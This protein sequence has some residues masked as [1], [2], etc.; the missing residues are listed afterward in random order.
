MKYKIL[1]TCLEVN[2][3][4]FLGDEWKKFETEDSVSDIKVDLFYRGVDCY[5]M[6]LLNLDQMK[7]SIKNESSI[8]FASNDWTYGKI[9]GSDAY[10]VSGLIEMILYSFLL[11]KNTLLFHSSLVQVDNKG[12]MFLGPSGVGKTTQATLW[13]KYKQATILNGDLV[14]VKKEEDAFYGYGSPWHGSSPYCENDRV[15]IKTM[16][17]LEQGK[18]NQLKNLAGFEVLKGIME[19]VFLPQWYQQAMDASLGT[20]DHLLESV[21]VYHLVNVADEE[22][23]KLVEE[24]LNNL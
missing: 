18:E 5:G 9:Y 2:G 13:Q 10:E 22:S 7:H 14:F 3:S 23:V 12:V 11:K 8:L 1:D 4:L 21:P 15:Q 6:E 17:V 24:K 19:Q 16:I 20:L